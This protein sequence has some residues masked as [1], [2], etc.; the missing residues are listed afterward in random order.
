MTETLPFRIVFDKLL[1]SG[2]NVVKP[3]HIFLA[4]FFDNKVSI[5]QKTFRKVF[6]YDYK[7]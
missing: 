1:F 2:Y 7:K 5:W 6:D 3:N 4:R